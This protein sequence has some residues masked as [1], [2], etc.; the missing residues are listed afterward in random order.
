[1]APLRL[2]PRGIARARAAPGVPV[3]SLSPPGR[4][5]PAFARDDTATVILVAGAPGEADYGQRFTQWMGDWTNACR[6]A[7]ARAITIGLSATNAISEK[8]ALGES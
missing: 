2:P 1:M 4:R 8:D 7:G 5:I 6:Q 3:H